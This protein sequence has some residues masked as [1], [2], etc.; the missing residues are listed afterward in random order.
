METISSSVALGGAIIT[1]R[2]PVGLTP[3]AAMS[4]QE[5]CIARVPDSLPPAVIGSDEVTRR[6]SPVL[7]H[8]QSAPIPAPDKVLLDSCGNLD[9]T[10][11]S[12]CSSVSFP[13]LKTLLLFM[14]E[15]RTDQ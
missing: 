7:S 6:F 15:I 8:A 3:H 4:L 12:N 11:D 14:Q 13:I 10:R 9:R 1:M 2:I 5:T